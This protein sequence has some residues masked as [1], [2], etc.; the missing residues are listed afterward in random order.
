MSRHSYWTLKNVKTIEGIVTP[1]VEFR[2]LEE[3]H[4]AG[5]AS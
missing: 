3:S 5:Q 4:N 1:E 2:E